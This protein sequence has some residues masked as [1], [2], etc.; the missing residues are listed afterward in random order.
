MTICLL[1]S[2]S[3]GTIMAHMSDRT[4]R[5]DTYAAITEGIAQA[6]KLHYTKPRDVALYIMVALDEHALRIVRRPMPRVGPTV[7]GRGRDLQS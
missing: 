7:T 5:E 3:A 4:K 2:A 6:R 1:T